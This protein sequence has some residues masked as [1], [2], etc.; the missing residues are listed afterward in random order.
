V[1]SPLDPKTGDDAG[2]PSL[3]AGPL[4]A[5][6][7][8]RYHIDRV[9]GI[10]GMATVYL[11]TDV[12]HDRP[13]ALKVLAPDFAHALG[14]ERF[15][16]EVRVAARMQHPHILSVFD[17]GE[18][19]GHLWYTMPFVDGES[20]RDRLRREKRL[21]LAEA[22]RIADQAA[23]A[24]EYAHRHG[25]IHRDVKPENLLLTS[26]GNTLVADFGI[27]RP[28]EALDDRLTTTGLGIGTPLYMSPEQAMGEPVLDARTDVYSLGAVVYEMLTGEPPHV[29][30]TAQAIVARQIAGDAPD[31]RAVRAAVPSH[32]AIAVRR[33]L[34]AVP[35]DRFETARE[36]AD[37]LK[38]DSLVDDASRTTPGR[39]RFAL[40]IGALGILFVAL[41][42]FGWRLVAHRTQPAAPAVN[43]IAVLPFAVHAGAGLATLR[44]GLVDLLSRDLDGAGDL[45]AVDATT[46]LSAARKD[47]Y[48]DLD[49]E[50][51]QRLARRVGATRFLLG[52]VTAI[53]S[54]ARIDAKIYDGASSPTVVLSSATVTGDTTRIVELLDK[55]AAN[56]LAG[57]FRG[58]GDHVPLIAATTTQSLGA[59]RAFLDGEE[60]LRRGDYDKAL[61][62]FQLAVQLDTAFA[63]AHYRVA[64][65]GSA[66]ERPTLVG[67][68]IEAALRHED[69][70][71]PRDRRLLDA[72]AALVDGR[73]DDAEREYR[74]LLED[75][76]NDV[77]VQ[78][79]LASTLMRYNPARGRPVQE[80]RPL[81][82]SVRRLEPSFGCVVCNLKALAYV[83]GA[84]ERAD[85]LIASLPGRSYTDSVVRAAVRHDEPTLQRL[86]AEARNAVPSGELVPT[87]WVVGQYVQQPRA[88]E[89]FAWAAARRSDRSQANVNS[90]AKLLLGL[91]RWSAADSVVASVASGP[92]A[93]WAHTSRALNAA[94]PF[95]DVPRAQLERIRADVVAEKMPDQ[96]GVYN[97]GLASNQPLNREYAIG[98]LSSR[99][100]DT[101]RALRAAAWLED[102]A[103]GAAHPRI[104]PSLAAAIRADVALSQGR[105]AAALKALEPVQGRIPLAVASYNPFTEDYARLLR[106]RALLALGRDDDALPWLVNGFDLAESDLVLRPHVALHLADIYERKG[107]R[108]RA[109]EQLDLF[110]RYWGD[111]EPR[112][113]KIVDDARA[114]LAR[115]RAQAS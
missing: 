114:R 1:S 36:F 107:D 48:G 45:H 83:D 6:V 100:G 42:A 80:A 115:L 78:W 98:L 16:R 2:A 77:E 30:P 72:F 67:P 3:L 18:V 73:P 10:G 63:L 91:G 37:A 109:A 50:A 4:A 21:S 23:Q 95:F 49:V 55:L 82:E 54:E 105:A 33:A 35:S 27:A 111:C 58:A 57:R 74:A 81:F 46:V 66:L 59:L 101:A 108:R 38:G 97:R 64:L 86:A 53:G 12:K 106:A 70:L 76:P 88:A 75:Y 32:V 103:A 25:V 62:P 17:S 26:D 68:G 28:M 112:L 94:Y 104:G 71:A 69:R 47:D 51:G 5:A 13:V 87:V 60:R 92:W 89:P 34:A 39:A 99:L 22:L 85:S 65:I 79:R 43:R 20:L 7:A 24:L 102:S 90:L 52:S 41:A 93:P 84:M 29:G 31:V 56:L 113:R 96:P 14:A 40:R 61:E 8:D 44:D 11:A 15:Q 110:L 19:A 9:L